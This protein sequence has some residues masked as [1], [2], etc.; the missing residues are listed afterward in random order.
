MNL[1]LWI[2]RKIPYKPFLANGPRSQYFGTWEKFLF[3]LCLRCPSSIISSRIYK[4][5]STF[6]FLSSVQSLSQ[7]WLFAIPWTAARQVSLSITN[8]QS[9]FKLISIGSV[10]PSNHL[11]LCHPLLL[12]SILGSLSSELCEP[13]M[14]LYWTFDTSFGDFL[15]LGIFLSRKSHLCLADFLLSYFKVVF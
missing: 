5:Y 13:C 15:P 10:M 3:R 2:L 7:V 14:L 4:L 12:P 11:I 1:A 8:S 9:L 6:S